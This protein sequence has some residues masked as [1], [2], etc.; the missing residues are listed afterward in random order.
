[1]LIEALVGSHAYGLNTPQSD[2]DY[3]GVYQVPTSHVLGVEKITDTYTQSG[4]EFENDLTMH[5]VGKFFKLAMQNNPTVLELLWLPEENYVA[6]TP[7]GELIIENRHLFLSKTVKDSFG[8]YAMAQAKR[9]ERRGDSFSSETKKRT[10]KHARHCFRL[11]R[12]GA[13]LLQ[14]GDMTVKVPNP[15]E[16]WEIGELPVDQIVKRFKKEFAKFEEIETILPDHP[17]VD[18]ISDLLVK[19]RLLPLDLDVATLKAELENAKDV[20]RTAYRVTGKPVTMF[21][22]HSLIEGR[23]DENE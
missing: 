15:E 3:L 6:L 5:E 7:V 14:T 11:M 17:D 22:A 9:L 16:L 12:Q 19:I 20:L 2:K 21:G 8:G 1:M 10:P 13:Q 18:A 4:P 23:R